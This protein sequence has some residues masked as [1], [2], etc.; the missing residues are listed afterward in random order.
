MAKLVV[1]KESGGDGF[2]FLR[3]ILVR[4]LV[5]AGL[6]FEDAYDLAQTARNELQGHGEITS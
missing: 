1:V 4:S 6:E 3:G 2:P 5:N